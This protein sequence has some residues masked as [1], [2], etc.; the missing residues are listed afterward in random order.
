MASAQLCQPLLY[1]RFVNQRYG[2]DQLVR[3][4]PLPDRAELS[5]RAG[6]R[7]PVRPRHKGVLQR[8]GNGQRRQ[9]PDQRI[10]V[11]LLL[12][13]ARFQEHLDEFFDEQ[14]HAIRFGDHLREH[15]GRG[16]LPISCLTIVS[17]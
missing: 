15:L 14:R 9:R 17:T 11:R 10:A 5:H 3:K 13:Q 7:Q 8:R 4:L 16:L 1:R 2:A 6:R 12:Y